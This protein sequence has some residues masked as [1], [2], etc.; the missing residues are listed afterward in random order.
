MIRSQR[1]DNP[2]LTRTLEASLEALDQALRRRTDLD[3]TIESIAAEPAYRVA[4]GAL[5]CFRGIDTLSAMI[6]VAEIVDFQRFRRPP[7]VV[8]EAWRAQ[9]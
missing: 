3:R 7:A 2:A 6:L 4:V 1:F 5:R 8:T 9:P